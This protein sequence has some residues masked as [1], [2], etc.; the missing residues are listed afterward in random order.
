MSIDQFVAAP[1]DLTKVDVCFRPDMRYWTRVLDV[2]EVEL[3]K[4][5]MAVGPASWDV[6]VETRRHRRK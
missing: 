6:R 1:A 3:R 4:A 2:T 5:E